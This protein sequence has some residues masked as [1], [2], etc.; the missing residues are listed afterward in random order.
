[1]PFHACAI[2]LILCH[3]SVINKIEINILCIR[4]FLHFWIISIFQKW[5]S[6]SKKVSL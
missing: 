2:D 4:L 3:F 5:D 1:M 6:R